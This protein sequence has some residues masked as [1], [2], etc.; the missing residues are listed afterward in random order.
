MKKCTH[1]S[2][3]SSCNLHCDKYCDEVIPIPDPVM[4]N[5]RIQ[6]SKSSGKSGFCYIGE[7]NG[8]RS[9][10]KVAKDDVC[11]SGKIYDS[12]EICKNPRLRK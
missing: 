2:G 12:K 1:D 3:S 9:C 5:S 6:S 11:I 7:E 10:V 4:D 8:I